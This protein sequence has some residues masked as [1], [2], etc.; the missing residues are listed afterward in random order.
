MIFDKN[1]PL[2]TNED[3]LYLRIQLNIIINIS[4]NITRLNSIYIKQTLR[5]FFKFLKINFGKRT[6]YYN[7]YRNI[8]TNVNNPRLIAEL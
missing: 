1:A 8:K 5:F 2:N 3:F 6:L 7:P 4:T